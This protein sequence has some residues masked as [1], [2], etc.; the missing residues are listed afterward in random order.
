[1]LIPQW[2]IRKRGR[3]LSLISIGGVQGSALVPPLNNHLISTRGLSFAWVFWAVLMATVMLPAGFFLIRN[4]PEAVG[5]RP[6]GVLPEPK[7]AEGTPVASTGGEERSWTLAEQRVPG[8]SGSCC[9]PVRCR[10]W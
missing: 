6:D 7:G 8:R 10:P 4:R 5:L 9:W 3:A 2:F 1:M